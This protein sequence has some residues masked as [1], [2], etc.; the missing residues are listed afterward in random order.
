M[1]TDMVAQIGSPKGDPALIAALALDGVQA[2]AFEVVAD[3][4]SKIVRSLLSAELP[5]L[6]PELTAGS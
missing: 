4:K 6:H 5:A 2:G 3:E 1:D